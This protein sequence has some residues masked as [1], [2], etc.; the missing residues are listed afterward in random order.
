MH[1][2]FGGPEQAADRIAALRAQGAGHVA[3]D[4][5][6]LPAPEAVALLSEDVLPR[7]V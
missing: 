4:V 6:G 5:R 1:H 3:L 2:V 7:V